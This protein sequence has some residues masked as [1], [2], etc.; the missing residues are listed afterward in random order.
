MSNTIDQATRHNLNWVKSVGE[1]AAGYR[2][3]FQ[4]AL[5]TDGELT[6]DPLVA[7]GLLTKR[8]DARGAIYT[9][10]PTGEAALHDPPSAD[11]VWARLLV[12]T[13]AFDD[14][15]ISDAAHR[16][17]E[18]EAAKWPAMAP[19]ERGERLAAMAIAF[20]AGVAFA[21]LTGER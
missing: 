2:H 9:L 12:T 19:E 15:S 16:F 13:D 11:A 7:R 5:P 18:H 17:A 20:D 10:T 4:P 14:R 6:L 8:L 21:K 3:S 1:R